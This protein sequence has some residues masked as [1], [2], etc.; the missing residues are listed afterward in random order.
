[1]CVCV[2]IIIYTLF[3]HKKRKIKDGPCENYAEKSQ[4]EK[5]KYYVIL[6]ISRVL[7]KPRLT[8]TDCKMVLPGAWKW[9]N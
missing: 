1:M 6:L 9:R 3:S 5:D 2:Y 8:E 4:L 7:K